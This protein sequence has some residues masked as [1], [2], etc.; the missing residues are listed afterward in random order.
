[1]SYLLI[2]HERV[3]AFDAVAHRRLQCG[4]MNG[5]QSYSNASRGRAKSGRSPRLASLAAV[6]QQG[7]TTSSPIVAWHDADADLHRELGSGEEKDHVRRMKS[8]NHNRTGGSLW[9]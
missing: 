4:R 2:A 9:W 6:R 8:D 3:L 1:L 5:K 7:E